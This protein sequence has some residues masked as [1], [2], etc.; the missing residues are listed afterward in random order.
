MSNI[1][2][3]RVEDVGVVEGKITK[4]TKNGE[5]SEVDWFKVEDEKFPFDKGITIREFNGKY[6]IEICYAEQ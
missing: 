4:I 5:M 1:R 6:V 3:I 2:Y